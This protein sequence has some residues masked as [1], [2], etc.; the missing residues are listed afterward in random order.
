MISANEAYNI[1]KSEQQRRETKD[2]LKIAIEMEIVYKFIGNR[3]KIACIS[4]R[5]SIS[6]KIIKPQYQTARTI[7]IG[8]EEVTNIYLEEFQERLTEL[9]YS[10]SFDEKTNMFKI[11][12]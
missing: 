11:N 10:W 6:F 2:H 1:T 4:G 9:L 8:T 12:W 5:R 3:I 7:Q